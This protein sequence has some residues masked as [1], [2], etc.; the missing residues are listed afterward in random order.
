MNF[1]VFV[2]L[3]LLALLVECIE[4]LFKDIDDAG[5]TFAKIFLN[6]HILDFAFAQRA[7]LSLY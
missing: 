7:F 6:R 1:I 2:I 3:M 4:P 5:M